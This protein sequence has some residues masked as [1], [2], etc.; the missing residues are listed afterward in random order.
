V[1]KSVNAAALTITVTGL[2]ITSSSHV[3]YVRFGD[4]PAASFAVD[5]LNSTEFVAIMTVTPPASVV[6]SHASG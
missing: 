2:R 1:A 4:M 3:D 6:C 5:A